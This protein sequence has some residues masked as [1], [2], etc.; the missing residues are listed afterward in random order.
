MSIRLFNDD[1]YSLN[2]TADYLRQQLGGKGMNL[3]LMTTKMGLPVPP[4]MTITT[5]ECMR[6]LNATTFPRANAKAKEM[7]SNALMLLASAIPSQVGDGREFGNPDNPLLVSVRSGA[8]VSMPGM[9]DTILNLG[10]NDDTVQGLAAKVNEPFAYDSYRRFLQMY[11]EIVLGVPGHAFDH[12]LEAARAFLADDSIPLEINKLLIERFKQITNEYGGVPFD[13]KKQLEGAIKAVWSSWNCDRAVAY[14]KVEGIPDD[15]GTAVN[16][17]AMV[18]GNMNDNSGTGVVFS[19]NPNT[20]EN[21]MYGDFLTNA[22][23]EDVVSGSHVTLPIAAMASSFPDQFGELSAHL[24]SLEAFFK[25]MVDVEFTIEDGKLWVLQTR[26]G[27]RSTKASI[28]ISLDMVKQNLTTS[29]EAAER[30]YDIINKATPVAA[31]SVDGEDMMPVGKGLPASEGIAVGK[32]VFSAADAVYMSEDGKESVI[33]ITVET[34]PDDIE[35]MAASAGVLTLKGGLV[36]HAAVVA[37]GWKK[38]CVVSLPDAQITDDGLHVGGKLVKAGDLVKING[39]TG[40][41][42]A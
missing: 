6:F 36:S 26:S 1:Y 38:P 13:H 41:V 22:Q 15:W 28:R 3:N 16:I 8:R 2:N 42:F 27:K 37:R 11:G 30:L 35:G 32:A 7:T 20:G 29:E 33:L 4:G 31:V 19:R 39:E 10:L 40:E 25:D 12:I 18:F 21:E 14:R 34:N 23:G 17:Q 24:T 9:M 5:S